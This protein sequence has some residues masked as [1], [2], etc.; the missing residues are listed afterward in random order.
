MADSVPH[1]RT[2]GEILKQNKNQLFKVPGNCPK[3]ILK[4]R[5]VYSRKFTKFQYEKQEFRV[6]Q[7]GPTPFPP[8]APVLM[9][10][11]PGPLLWRGAPNKIEAPPPQL[12]VGGLSI[13]LG[14]TSCF[15][16]LSPSP[17]YIDPMLYSSQ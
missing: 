17:I 7:P 15:W 1:Q 4:R 10:L 16:F 8:L 3:D 14:G 13:H 5:R 11:S 12:T 2:T 9:T 6:V